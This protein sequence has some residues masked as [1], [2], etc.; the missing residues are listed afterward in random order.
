VSGA[1]VGR[2]VH[3]RTY[4]N[5]RTATR[6]V[7]ALVTETNDGETVGLCIAGPLSIT[8]DRSVRHDE[9]QDDAT[10]HWPCVITEEHE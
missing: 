6:C 9:G 8:F 10:W 5:E 2:I 3:Y 1:T 7:P 4:D